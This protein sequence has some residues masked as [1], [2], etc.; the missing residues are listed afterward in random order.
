MARTQTSMERNKDYR[1]IF[2]FFSG[3][4]EKQFQKRS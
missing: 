3:K 2:L 4:V 1:K